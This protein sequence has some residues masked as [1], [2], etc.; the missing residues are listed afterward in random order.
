MTHR[1]PRLAQKSGPA[2]MPGNTSR[3][4]RAPPTLVR[5]LSKSH[6]RVICA[7][8]N[9]MMFHGVCDLPLDEIALRAGVSRGSV[10][11]ALARAAKLGLMEVEERR[12]P[13]APSRTNVVRMK[14]A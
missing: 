2:L 9:E 3:E 5:S 7:V 13:T 1:A 14:R 4:R 12:S 8:W 10:R 6:S 11:G